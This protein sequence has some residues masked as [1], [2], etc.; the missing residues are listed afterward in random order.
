MRTRPP[1]G[2]SMPAAMRKSVV[3]PHP[4]GPSRHT[5]SAGAMSSEKP[6]KAATPA[7]RRS[8]SWKVRRAAMVAPARPARG[9]GA[10]PSRPPR[11]IGLLKLA[12]GAFDVVA[13][14]EEGFRIPLAAFHVKEVA[15]IDVD[16]TR[17]PADR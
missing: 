17:Q 8:T 7:Q 15:A 5:T 14:F 13:L 2:R 9:S 4:E 12:H 11:G 1:V 6:A 16:G 10:F 3:L